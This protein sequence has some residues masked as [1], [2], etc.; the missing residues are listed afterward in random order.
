MLT[1]GCVPVIIC[2]LALWASWHRQPQRVHVVSLL[3][4]QEQFAHPEHT[5]P[6][7]VIVGHVFV[8]VIQ[9]SMSE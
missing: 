7:G 6:V 9:L 1:H 4:L 3:Q 5:E 2:R 8:A